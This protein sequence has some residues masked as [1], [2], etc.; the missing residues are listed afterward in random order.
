MSIGY[1]VTI[2]LPSLAGGGAERS[3]VTIANGLSRFGATVTLVLA[4]TQGPYLGEL[5]SHVR[6]VDLRARSAPLALIG[7]LHHLRTSRPAAVLSAMNHANVVVALA[8]RF[9]GCDTRLV[10]SERV[11]LSSLFEHARDFRTG[12]VRTLMR[13]TYPMADRLIAVSRGV[14]EDLL[15]RIP[16]LRGR[17]VTIYNPVVDE[18]LRTMATAAPTHPWL[19]ER[20]VPVILAAGRLIPQKDFHT[21]ITAFSILRK[22]RRARLIIL[23]E[24][25]LRQSLQLCASQFGVS[26][27]V[28]LP[29]FVTNP[30]SAMAAASVFVLSSR[31]EGLPGAL[32][33]AMACGSSVVSTDCPSGPREVLEDGRWG[34][35]VPVGDPCAMA[36]A[37]A[38]AID[39][40]QPPDV[41]ARAA[42]FAEDI[43]I[44]RYAEAV[45]LNGSFCH[46][47]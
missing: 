5:N 3:I 21:L 35:L 40:P 28:A 27:D 45:G 17:T 47:N 38:A 20:N 1:S 12:V 14:E 34:A 11:H 41:R 42:A 44:S 6:V 36:S 16:S 29:G 46:R 2:Y 13:V 43:A 31:F 37:I 10:L 22:Q 8:V 4:S 23:G 25:G 24:G 33:Q 15:H 18:R 30:F 19:V 32:I 9:S 26:E 39:N 7:L